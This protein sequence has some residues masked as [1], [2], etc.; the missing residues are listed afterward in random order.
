MRRR[1]AHWVGLPVRFSA[2]PKTR[3]ELGLIPSIASAADFCCR[4]SS[5]LQFSMAGKVS[6]TLTE[7]RATGP[8]GASWPS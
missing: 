5:L 2:R 7:A 6:S 8:S 1:Q 4:I 3:G